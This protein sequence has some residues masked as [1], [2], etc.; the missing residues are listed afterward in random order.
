MPDPKQMSGIPRPVDRPAGRH[1]S[2]R[3]IRGDLSNNIANHP[4]ELHVGAKVHDRRR[5]TSRPR[6]V[7]RAARRAPR[8]RRWPSSTA[9]ASS[10]RS[11]RRRRRAASGCML[12]A[13]DKERRRRPTTAGAPPVTG[14]VVLG[15]ESRIVIEPAKRR[16]DVFYLLD[17]TNTARAPVNPPTPFVVRHADGRQR[18]RDH[19]RARRR[20]RA[21]TGTRVTVQGRFRRAR[22]SCRLAY[23]MPAA[24]RLGRHRRSGFR[25]PSSSWPCRQESRRARRCSS[26][27]IAKQQEMPAEGETLHRRDGRRGRG[28]PADRA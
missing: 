7:R 28:R 23:A 17:I 14:Q 22:R 20:R 26:P 15:G 8:S 1:V 3:L 27:Q 24:Q 12:V 11:F 18:R 5:P 19:A 16:C 2:V 10:R 4:V 21:S 25:R 9:S 6:A 13:T